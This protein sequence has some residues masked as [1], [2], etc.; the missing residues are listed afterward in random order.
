MQRFV[1]TEL[2][3]YERLL[4]DLTGTHASAEHILDSLIAGIHAT[5]RRP[6][7]TVALLE[8]CLGGAR[9]PAM[10]VVATRCIDGYR[11]ITEKA[12][13][14]AGVPSEQAV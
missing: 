5:F 8:I 1:D 3:G 12:L 13:V 10:S 6:G 9:Q 4:A 7:H 14:A 11:R 2:E